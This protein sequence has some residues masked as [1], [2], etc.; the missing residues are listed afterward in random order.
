[1]FHATSA[2][3]SKALDAFFFLLNPSPVYEI[4]FL[5]PLPPE[6][7]CGAGGRSPQDVANHV[8]R[9][10]AAAL[11]F[12]CTSLTRRDKYRALAGHDGNVPDPRQKQPRHDEDD[13]LAE[14]DKGFGQMR[15]TDR[16]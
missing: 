8:Q 5:S 2:R 15:Q 7:T 9:L 11:G 10:L 3:R 6:H 14:H 1:M 13:K 4:A 12:E 16:R